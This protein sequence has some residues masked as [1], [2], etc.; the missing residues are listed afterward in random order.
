[1]G[2][3]KK[4]RSYAFPEISPQLLL[5]SHWP[6]LLNSFALLQESLGKSC[7]WS[8]LSRRE[9]QGKRRLECLLNETISE[10]A[11]NSSELLG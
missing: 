1:M 2:K 9:K 8:S 3:K 5:I 4:S 7:L 6:Q 11:K 10:S